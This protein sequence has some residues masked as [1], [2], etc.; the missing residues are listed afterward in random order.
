MR[1]E[2]QQYIHYRKGSLVFYA[3]REEIGE[4]NLNRALGELHS[5]QGVPAAAVHDDARA[6]RLHPRADAGRRSRR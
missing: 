3:L 5:R 6:A 4:E 1:V 2:N